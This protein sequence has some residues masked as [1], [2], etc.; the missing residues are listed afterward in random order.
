M[1]QDMRHLQAHC[2]RGLGMGVRAEAGG[3][4]GG[5]GLGP[6]HRNNN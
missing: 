2:K 3:L 4:E 5:D 6:V 1:N